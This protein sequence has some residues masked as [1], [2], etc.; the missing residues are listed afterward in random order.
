ME[1][2]WIVNSLGELGVKVGGRFF[3]LYKGASIEYT[4]VDE[5]EDP[6]RFR[7]VLKREFG[8]VCIP[9]KFVAAG[10]CSVPDSFFDETDGWELL[11]LPPAGSP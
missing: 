9:E 3:F 7:K 10:Y 1:P 4:V 11:P 8:E 2:E 5:C 6:I